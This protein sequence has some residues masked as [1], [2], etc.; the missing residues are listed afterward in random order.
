MKKTILLLLFPIHLFSQD[1]TSANGRMTHLTAMANRVN[2]VVKNEYTELG[3][4]SGLRIQ[5]LVVTDQ[6]INKSASGIKIVL[7]NKAAGDS[8]GYFS[9]VDGEDIGG[10]V[11]FL[12]DIQNLKDPVTTYTGYNYSCR[13][14][15]KVFATRKPG[16]KEWTKSVYVDRDY[17]ESLLELTPETA[18]VL[19]EA[20]I[21]AQSK[22]NK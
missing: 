19:I 13:G 9:Y 1:T 16:E 3:T 15:F 5:L 14:D 12:K 2:V 17:P 21:S 6:S 18:S 4:F 20:L 7:K 11:K 10:L 8:P 22:L